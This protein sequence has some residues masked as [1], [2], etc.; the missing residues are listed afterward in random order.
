M[1]EIRKHPRFPVNFGNTFSGEQIAGQGIIPN[2]SV[3]G[4]SIDSKVTL[5]VNRSLALHIT[6]AG[7]AMASAD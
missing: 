1:A 2:L 7:L 4:C 5:T 3:G 6:T